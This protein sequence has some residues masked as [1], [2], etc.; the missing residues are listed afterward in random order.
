MA[1]AD[2]LFNLTIKLAY[3][4]KNSL[5]IDILYLNPWSKL[6]LFLV[7]TH[8]YDIVIRLDYLLLTLL[9]K[10]F[11][12]HVHCIEN[13]LINDNFIPIWLMTLL[14]SLILNNVVL[15]FRNLFI[16]FFPFKFSVSIIMPLYGTRWRTIH[17]Q[18]SLNITTWRLLFWIDIRFSTSAKLWK[19]NWTSIDYIMDYS[20][21]LLIPRLILK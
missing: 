12:H 11:F 6:I 14:L 17:Q 18:N 19:L 13:Y 1:T 4:Y 9:I 16:R 21:F 8:S 3:L 7:I 2:E 15:I 10:L 20:S 5:I